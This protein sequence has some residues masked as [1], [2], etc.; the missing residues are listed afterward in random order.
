MGIILIGYLLSA[1][2]NSWTVGVEKRAL[3]D[4]IWIDF[5]WFDV[6]QVLYYG[7]DEGEPNEEEFFDDIDNFAYFML[8]VAAVEEGKVNEPDRFH[9]FNIQFP[10]I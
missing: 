1:H 4:M 5:N 9:Q 10:F 6:H 2:C 7:H 3:I 8:R